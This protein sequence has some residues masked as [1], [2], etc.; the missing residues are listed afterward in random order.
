M[1]NSCSDKNIFSAFTVAYPQTALNTVPPQM[2]EKFL[3]LGIEKTRDGDIH[4]AIDAT[5]IAITTQEMINK[6]TKY[7]QY[8]DGKFMNNKGEYI[9]L[10]TGEI[11]DAKEYEEKNGIYFPEPWDKFRKE[12]EIR[13]NCT[14]KERMI[15]C[16]N[17]EKIFTYNS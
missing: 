8:K 5:V 11:L 2:A 10:E 7:Y 17:A 9:D 3:S 15:E 6:L 13:V 16:L 12:L 1:Y 14:S 4:H